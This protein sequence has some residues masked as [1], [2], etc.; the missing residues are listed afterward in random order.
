MIL[1]AIALLQAAAPVQTN[2]TAEPA[3]VPAAQPADNESSE[4]APAEP[5]MKRV[6]HMEMDPG[7]RTLASRHRVCEYVRA[8]KDRSKP[9]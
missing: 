4:T 6:C 1:F 9:K 7:V 3:P 5:T 8:D 2:A